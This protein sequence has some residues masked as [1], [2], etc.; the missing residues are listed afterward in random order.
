MRPQ[1]LPFTSQE[2]EMSHRDSAPPRQTL[3]GRSNSPVQPRR[4][5]NTRAKSVL[6]AC[7]EDNHH[8]ARASLIIS[9]LQESCSTRRT[10]S[11]GTPG[12]HWEL[13]ASPAEEKNWSA[14]RPPQ[15]QVGYSHTQRKAEEG[16]FG[17]RQ[18]SDTLISDGQPLQL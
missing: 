12:A 9:T 8:E 13:E 6:T 5:E 14:P 16:G 2:A 18:H 10:T 1:T 3:H 17:R 4:R 11:G 7:S 15:G